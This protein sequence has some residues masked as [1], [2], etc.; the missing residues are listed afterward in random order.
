MTIFTPAAPAQAFNVIHRFSGGSGG[1]Y[2]TG[3]VTIDAS[4][5]L[6]GT[7]GLGTG[8]DGLVFKMSQRNSQ[9]L[10][11]PLYN[12]TGNDGYGPEGGVIR[13]RSGVLYGATNIGGSLGMGTVFKLQPS[14][15]IPPS[16][17][18]PWML[19]TL[20]N[21]QPGGGDG[22]GPKSPLVFDQAGNLYGTTNQ[23]GTYG[24]GV[25]FKLTPANGAWTESILYNFGQGGDGNGPRSG[26]VSDSV[27]NLYGTTEL[28]GAY[29][30]GMVY[31]LS[32]SGANWNESILYSFKGTGDGCRPWG[33]VILDQAGNLY[34][35]TP[36]T[37][38]NVASNGVVFELS[39]SGGQ[40]N[41][42]LLYAFDRGYVNN[43]SDGYG[44]GPASSLS[45]DSS[46]ALYGTTQG[47]GFYEAGNVFKLT[48]SNGGWTY[49]SL[50]DFNNGAGD[51]YAVCSGVSFDSSGNLYGTTLTG[52]DALGVVWEITP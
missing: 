39:P 37:D 45:M 10:L 43:C 7:A 32:S 1:G 41:Y 8:D 51:G 40:W 36:M 28:G 50:H 33:G 22:S 21:F 3:G 52:G 11:N 14:P 34:G 35:G 30:C 6:Y 17:F 26:V 23:G 16:V 47:D 46:G 13:D 27:G 49:T 15:V 20:H 4:G 24:G 12:F 44:T 2:P 29:G 18:S 5:N 19:T 25:V 31:Q 38:T 42:S 48:S 9:W